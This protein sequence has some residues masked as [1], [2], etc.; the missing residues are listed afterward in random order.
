VEGFTAEIE[1]AEGGERL[2][3]HQATKMIGEVLAELD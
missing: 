1:A 2:P 3:A